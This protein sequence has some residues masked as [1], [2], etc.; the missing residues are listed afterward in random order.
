MRREY[1]SRLDIGP[2]DARGL[3]AHPW[4][5]RAQAPHPRPPG[6]WDRPDDLPAH[7]RGMVSAERPVGV[8]HRR[9]GAT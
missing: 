8:R 1:A 6:R 2:G 3:R 9:V 7:R 4:S 5:C